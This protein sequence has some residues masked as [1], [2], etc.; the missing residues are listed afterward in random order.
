VEQY[1]SLDRVSHDNT[2]LFYPLGKEEMKSITDGVIC[3]KQSW[4]ELSY[5]AFCTC[6]KYFPTLGS[7]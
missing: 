5:R 2:L 4:D 1:Y 7:T 3:P 6:A